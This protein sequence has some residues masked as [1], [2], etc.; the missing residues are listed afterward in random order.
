MDRR[1]FLSGVAV[2]LVAESLVAEAQQVG[3]VWRVAVMA[4]PTQ[5]PFRRFQ[6]R[7]RD[8]GYIE[9]QNL[10]LIGRSYQGRLELASKIAGELLAL[11]PDVL[12]AISPPGAHAAK[13]ATT[14][15][16]IVFVSGR[17]VQTGLVRDL[18][19]PGG[20]I[21]GLSLDVGPEIHA[22]QLQLLGEV[23]GRLSRVSVLSNPDNRGIDEY[24]GNVTQAA[25]ASNAQVHLLAVRSIEDLE[26]AFQAA[27][28]NRSDGLVVLPDLLMF[29]QR[30]KVT[31][32]ARTHRIPAIYHFKEFVEA[33]GL[34]C[35]GPNAVALLVRAADYVDKIFKG[36]KPGDLPV[37]Q[38]TTFELVINLKTAKELGLT[39]PQSLLLRADE[40]IQ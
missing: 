23:V 26:S 17:P 13:A 1:T 34:L 36:A 7:L 10:E 39:I 2:G 33:G 37:E 40:V 15:V 29:I 22:K 19:R 32:L 18:A 25:R 5:P 28:K 16:P 38:P 11:K 9:G 14:T 27:V 3:K 35:Y 6:L 31:A 4:D 8:L 20:N 12:V 24:V 21:T 30:L